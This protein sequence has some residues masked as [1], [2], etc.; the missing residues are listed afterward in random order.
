M[1]GDAINWIALLGRLVPSARHPR[2]RAA[3]A[4]AL[5]RSGWTP[6]APAARMRAVERGLRIAF[7]DAG[8]AAVREMA[9]RHAR[10]MVSFGLARAVLECGTREEVVDFC[11]RRVEV[12]GGEH[13]RAARD[14]AGPV[15]FFSA[16]YG[17]PALACLRIGLELA[18]HKRVNTF[19]ARPEDN[20]ANAGYQELME[21]VLPD[22]NTLPGDGRA[23]KAGLQALRR[24]EALTMQPDVYDNRDGTAMLV[25]FLGRLT[26]AMG[27]T[28]FFALR[29]K[30]MLVPVYCYDT[31][32]GRFQARFDAPLPH[33]DTGN[34][35]DDV[36]A[37]TARIFASMEAQIRA[38]PEH[39]A[40]WESLPGRLLADVRLPPSPAPELWRDAFRSLSTRCRASL[41]GAEGFLS[42]LEARLAAPELH[43]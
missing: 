2:A 11:A 20:A 24:G 5:L 30:A 37:L 27:G 13:L 10:S 40:Y 17:L 42:E 31:G 4:R 41:P 12:A 14:H 6:P 16:H 8:D 18:G 25:P 28:A 38:V 3:A 26:F 29:G 34:L 35:D 1:T 23:V 7:P 43:P 33:P 15:I 32:R 21:K 36:Y 39:W 22:V 9:R 19:Y